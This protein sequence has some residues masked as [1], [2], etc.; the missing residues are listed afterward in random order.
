[1]RP[2]AIKPVLS[3]LAVAAALVL[4]ACGNKSTS[5][6]SAETEG[7]FL[8]V[9]QL[10]YQVEISRQLNPRAIPEDK[11]FVEDIDP[12]QRTLG[13]DELW[14]AVFVR[15]ENETDSPQVPATHYTITDTEG[16]IYEP[17]KI[18]PR[19]PFFY[20]TSPIGPGAAAPN[21]DAVASQLG[22]IGGMELLFKLKRAALDNRPLELLIQSIIPADEATD[23]LD[24]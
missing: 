18:G 23:T 8:N 16:N 15:I 12:A 4:G 20:D 14:F 13:P 24:V 1:M 11:T 19:N 5:I 17:V 22:A 21:P 2:I 10:K 3:T 9:G 6:H 7:I